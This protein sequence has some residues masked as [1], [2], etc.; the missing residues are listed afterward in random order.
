MLRITVLSPNDHNQLNLTMRT[1]RI[2]LICTLF[3]C[4]S[5]K[6]TA[7]VLL[8]GNFSLGT[9]FWDCSPEIQLESVV[10]GIGSNNVAEIDASSYICQDITGLVP[11]W[12]YYVSLNC[13]RRTGATPGPSIT[14][15]NM[16][17]L[18]S[19]SV[20]ITRTN[21]VYNMTPAAFI[22]TA[23]AFTQPLFL[24][25]TV[26]L[27]GT[28]GMIVDNIATAFSPL[29]IELIS[30]DGGQ[31]GTGIGLNWST[32]SEKNNQYF[33]IE[34]SADGTDFT[35]I[36]RVQSK[37][38]AGNSSSRLDYNAEDPN[39][40]T[41]T[42]YYRLKQVDTDGSFTNSA[43]ITV[44]SE[45]DNPQRIEIFPNPGEGTFQIRCPS[46][47]QTAPSVRI[48]DLTGQLLEEQTATETSEAR[49]FRIQPRQPLSKGCYQLRIETNGASE[50]DRLIVN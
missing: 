45:T 2:V 5:T 20:T 36:A 38:V 29:S 40:L 28:S 18:G 4:G 31:K 1:L 24:Y 34:R 25:A 6:T 42:N 13:S 11:G 49:I 46:T 17:V 14:T 7:Q 48:F 41:G 39:P 9:L 21:T 37:S 32:S 47:N 43:I 33:E 10:G 35:T 22:F 30:F 15:I 16:V 12:T 26:S 3:F 27:T 44:L 8:N 50:F 19:L 23:T